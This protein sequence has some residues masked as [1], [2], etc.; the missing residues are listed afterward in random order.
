MNIRLL[1]LAAAGAF[2]L[3]S[4]SCR[5]ETDPTVVISENFATAPGERWAVYGE[6]SL[7]SWNSAAQEL[8]VTWD[9]S[10]TNSY[11][12]QPLRTV[13]SR[14][15]DFKLSFDLQFSDLTGG[16]EWAVGLMKFS[17]ATNSAYFRG[18]GSD[19]PNFFEIAYF[20]PSIYGDGGLTPAFSATN[21][22]DSTYNSGMSSGWI[23]GNL[24][25]DVPIHF[26]VEYTATNSA[27]VTLVTINGVTTTNTTLLDKA[28]TDFQVDSF[29]IK[30]Y[31]DYK[32]FGSDLLAHASVK[33][34]M[35][36]VAPVQSS[37]GSLVNGVWQTSVLSLTNWNY[38]LVSSTNLT[39]WTVCSPR[40]SGT[41]ANITL[42]D[43]NTIPNSASFYR[44]KAQQYN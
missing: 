22:W 31:S 26:A 4:L 40:V 36:Q 37:E 39:Q 10:K 34:V 25:M 3:S 21:L 9:S 41:G 16:F 17:D 6:S 28:F 19:S 20:P 33:N 1:T 8:D 29:A 15:H 23:P 27:A 5:A 13:L 12:Y 35:V 7:F 14:T 38:T 43:T 18:T 2:V 32:G 42:G 30:N 24:P 11:F 44:V